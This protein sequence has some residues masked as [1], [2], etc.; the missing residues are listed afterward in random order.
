MA[1]LR[2]VQRSF[3]VVGE[4]SSQNKYAL[5]VGLDNVDYNVA[6]MG[7][8]S[9]DRPALA[10]SYLPISVGPEHMDGYSVSVRKNSVKGFARLIIW[11][12]FA[13]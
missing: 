2:H 5:L 7:Y 12:R 3:R 10:Y 6:F 11:S 4:A 8:R 9:E 1:Q 13:H